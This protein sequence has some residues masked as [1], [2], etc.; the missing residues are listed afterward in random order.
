MANRGTRILR[1]VHGRDAV[2]HQKHLNGISADLRNQLLS[3]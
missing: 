2:P 1:V 3:G